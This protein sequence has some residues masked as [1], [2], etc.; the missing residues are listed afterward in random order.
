[1]ISEETKSLIDSG[2]GEAGAFEFT[3]M[4]AMPIRGKTEEVT[5]YAVTNSP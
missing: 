2:A 1:M 3:A 4:G 5:A